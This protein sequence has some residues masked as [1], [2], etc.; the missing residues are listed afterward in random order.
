VIASGSRFPT[1]ATTAGLAVLTLPLL[2]V[3]LSLALSPQSNWTVRA[4]LVAFCLLAVSRPGAALLVTT[5]LIGFG[6]ILSHMAGVPPLR[7]T[8]V[9]V[10]ASLAG[11]GLR[12]IATGS[13]VR[14]ALWAA[15]PV[16]VALLAV[17]AIASTVVW[18]RVYQIETGYPSDYFAALFR[19][20]F[21]DYFVE[22]GNFRLLVT[23][24]A[25]LEGLALYVVVAALCRA[26]KTFFERS[27][28]MLALGGAGLGV[29]SVVRLVEVS[30][31]N[32]EALEALRA[33]AAG[34][35]ISPQ[36]PDYI[37]AGS[38][39][40]LCWLVALGLAIV[41]PRR[42]LLWAAAG[43]PLMAALYLTGS[44][45]V[46][47][48]AFVGL[49]ALAVIALRYRTAAVGR[50]VAFGLA[51]VIVMVITYPWMTG[52]DVVGRTAGVS[53]QTR[54]ELAR[55]AVSVIETRPL[56]GIGFDRF[57]DLADRHA[58]PELNALWR[59][60]KNP[61][62]DF[63]RIGAELGLIGLGLFLWILG[64]AGHRIW[65]TLR[66]APDIHLAALT[67]GLLAFL[68]T[69]LI[70]DPLMFREVSYAFWIA[71]GL[72]VGHSRAEPASASGQRASS[73]PRLVVSTLAVA[74]AVLLVVSIP[75]RARQ[76][77]Q[78]IDLTHV[79]Y[80]F[81]EW[82]LDDEGIPNRWSGPRA[83]L[84]VDG[85]A[86]LVELPVSATLPGDALQQVEVRVDGRLANRLSVGSEWQRLRLALPVTD[87][88]SPRRIDLLVSPTW[89]PAEVIHNDDRR[90]LGVK[91][92]AVNVLLT[93]EDR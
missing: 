15:T 5:A 25:L 61:H 3:L 72:A 38:Y 51:G 27:L 71:L 90:E 4:A 73:P 57:Q 52:R 19:F 58:S 56:L 31:R 50:I 84:F 13:A 54:V 53:V 14:R 35:R 68:A 39:F 21:R 87:G 6:S 62:N 60:R 85:R 75:F 29:L 37:A 48:A 44:R 23:T 63:L 30:I 65:Q 88:S 24:A 17:A 67:G 42:R 12:A 83:T 49:A 92:G 22:P 9:L 86:R 93:D 74:I 41:S 33:T 10:V 18:Q 1:W 91:V 79:T 78:E 47:G 66:T 26:E 70:S 32:P 20:L 11:F 89:V 69:S 34:L 59:A 7:V 45:S 80:G 82:V 64:A 81:F 28:R 2:I 43:V 16:P 8:E 77:L 46:I 76:E 55:T 40:S 36:I